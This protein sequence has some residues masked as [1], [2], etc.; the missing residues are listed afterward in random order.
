M[1]KHAHGDKHIKVLGM[2]RNN[3]EYLMCCE[4]VTE[5]DKNLGNKI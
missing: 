1:L 4:C 2:G 5:I 3:I